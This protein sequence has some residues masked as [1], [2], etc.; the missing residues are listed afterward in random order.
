MSSR[1]TS[2][3]RPIRSTSAPAASTSHDAS[4]AKL[5]FDE[6]AADYFAMADD[7]LTA[8]HL[9]IPSINAP[10]MSGQVV[11]TRTVTNV[12]NKKVDFDLEGIAPA[13]SQITVAPKTIHVKPGESETFTITITSD[14]PGQ[15]F[16]EV[17]L[18][19]KGPNGQTLHLP[20]AFIHTQGGCLAQ[21]DVRSDRASRNMAR[22]R[23]R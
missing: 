16:G 19:E 1:K 7:P 15:Q 3:P 17:V 14:A 10:V 11:T 5:T 2:P 12:T 8:I 4:T 6:T 9:N 13:G 20:V 23:V 21:S 22:R 18:T